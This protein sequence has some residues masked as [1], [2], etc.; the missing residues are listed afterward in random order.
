M[1]SFISKGSGEFFE[2][3]RTVLE[4]HRASQEGQFTVACSTK[5]Q[6]GGNRYS[7]FFQIRINGYSPNS[8]CFTWEQLEKYL[9]QPK[10]MNKI[11]NNK[12]FLFGEEKILNVLE[13]TGFGEVAFVFNRERNN[14]LIVVCKTTISYRTT[15]A[16][17]N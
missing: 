7:K 13:N 10:R 4:Q 11:S 3:F 8:F 14:R 17:V 6:S 12:L 16:L 15:I 9:S 1:V 5:K 2:T